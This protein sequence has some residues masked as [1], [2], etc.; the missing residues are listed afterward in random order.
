VGS[1]HFNALFVT[2]PKALEVDDLQEALRR[3]RAQGAFLIWD[4]PGFMR[5]L[6][7]E[8]HTHVDEAYRAG[9]FQGVELVNGADFYPEVF[10]WVAEKKLTIVASSDAHRPLPPRSTAPRP[11]TLLFVR[12]A[13][14]DGVKEALES[15]R[16]AAWLG[17]DVWGAEE[18]L[19]GLWAGAVSFD[20]L[21]AVK[22]GR[23]V[24]VRIRNTSA[25]AFR[26]QSPAGPARLRLEAGTIQARATSLLTLVVADD[27]PAG[28][29][30]AS[31]EVE[32]ANLHPGPGELRA[33]IP[34]ELTIGR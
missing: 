15:R 11:I 18:H 1:G 13:D 32:V 27:A 25:I 8:W 14:A 16:T 7:P 23:R 12:S 19:R 3:A 30:R 2:D 17:D 4:H 33:S 20:S 21:P 22:A 10:P 31:V 5:T 26:V 6:V 28:T 9:L 34:V 24:N 29:E